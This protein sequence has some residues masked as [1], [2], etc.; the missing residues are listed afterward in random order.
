MNDDRMRP[1]VSRS[2]MEWGTKANCRNMDT[3]MWFPEKGHMPT[4][5]VREVCFSCDVQLQ[6]LEYAQSN[7]MEEGVWGGCTNG[8]RENLRR[9]R[10]T[11]DRIERRWREQAERTAKRS[12][13]PGQRSEESSVW[14]ALGELGQAYR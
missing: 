7:R 4:T 1:P 12:R 11:L 9:G 5:F 13:R 14:L 6:C 2:G 3:N 8:E 10:T